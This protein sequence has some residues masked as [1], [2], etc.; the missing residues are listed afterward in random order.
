MVYG[1]FYNYENDSLKYNLLFLIE[2]KFCYIFKIIVS[3][4]Y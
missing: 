1:F 2:F 4:Y 3:K